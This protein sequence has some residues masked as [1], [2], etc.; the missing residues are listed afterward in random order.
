MDASLYAR[1]RPI[2]HVFIVYWIMLFSPLM[3]TISDLD[4]D[5]QNSPYF[6]NDLCLIEGKED[7]NQN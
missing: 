5:D 7:F 1:I 6:L 4:D 2:N 3:D